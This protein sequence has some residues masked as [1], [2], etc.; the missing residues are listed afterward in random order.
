MPRKS[1]KTKSQYRRSEEETLKQRN[2]RFEK[3]MAE[4]RKGKKKIMIKD[5]NNPRCWIEKWIPIEEEK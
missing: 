2:K 1:V 3:E 5:P 4:K